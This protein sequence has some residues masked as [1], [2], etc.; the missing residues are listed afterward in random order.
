MRT[1][2]DKNQVVEV[3][4][5]HVNPGTYSTVTVEMHDTL[6]VIFLG[7][8]ALILLALLWEKKK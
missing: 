4:T 3:E 5:P 6:D 2:E 1:E 7:I 8:I